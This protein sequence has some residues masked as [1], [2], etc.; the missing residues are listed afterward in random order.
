MH[1]FPRGFL[2]KRFLGQRRVVVPSNVRLKFDLQLKMM[3]SGFVGSDDISRKSSPFLLVPS[4]QFLT[5][6]HSHSCVNKGFVRQKLLHP[7]SSNFS[8]CDGPR[9]VSECCRW[10]CPVLGR[11]CS[12]L[13]GGLG[14][15][16]H[17]ILSPSRVMLK[18]EVIRSWHRLKMTLVRQRPVVPRVVRLSH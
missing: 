13:G 6:L 16:A 4:Q 5:V 15:P 18:S 2:G 10:R 3:H 17:D 1:H 12:Q 7:S 8:S 14:L 11:D 9:G